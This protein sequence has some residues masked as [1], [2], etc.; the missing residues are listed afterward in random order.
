MPQEPKEEKL[1][2]LKRE[3][4]RTMAKDIAGVRERQAEKERERIANLQ[5]EAKLPKKPQIVLSQD[6]EERPRTLPNNS[7]GDAPTAVDLNPAQA[8]QVAPTPKKQ[9]PLLPRRPLKRSEKLFIRFL[10]GGVIVFLIFNAVAF[11]FW[12]LF[13]RDTQ[14][15]PESREIQQE[16]QAPS[17]PATP[18]PQP[19][20]PKADSVETPPPPPSPE[21][22]LPQVKTPVVF[23]EAPEQELFLETPEKLLVRLKGFLAEGPV[24]GFT[25]LVLKTKGDILSPQEFLQGTKITIPQ[26]LRE[27]LGE[28]RMLFSYVTESKK[29]LG[30]IM[31]LKKTESVSGL[32]QSWEPSMEQDLASFFDIIG[33]KGAAYT[34]FFR[35][36]TYQ[37]V[38]VRFQTFSVIDFGIV[39]GIVQDKLLLTS[40]LESF[41]K[42]VDQLKAI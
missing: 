10:I 7:P 37:G 4:I 3:E 22:L 2:F 12:Y 16:I 15:Q 34:P 8:K 39:Y 9:R 38:Q 19:D 32:L 27:K 18:E 31:D 26:E 28:N 30:F 42:A 13:K 21:V 25:S 35:P 23:F 1:E 36:T 33:R 24:L 5:R 20:Q 17:P 40:S 41:R 11:G 14:K 29:R 6:P